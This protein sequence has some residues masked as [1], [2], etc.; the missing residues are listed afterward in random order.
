[1]LNTR[2]AFLY[3]VSIL[4]FNF[5]R[6]FFYRLFF[7]YEIEDSSIGFGTQIDCEQVFLKGS[8]IGGKNIVNCKS[9][10][11]LES[12]IGNANQFTGLKTIKLEN[13]SISNNNSFSGFIS[14][15]MSGELDNRSDIGNFNRFFLGAWSRELK[16]GTVQLQP[17]AKITSSHLFDL[18]CDIVI[19]RNSVIAGRESQFW[20]HGVGINKSINIGDL[21]YI[22]S[23]CRFAPGA[24]T[25]N[26]IIVGMGSVVTKHI[27]C[28]NAMIAGV[29][30]KIIKSNY[31][32]RSKDYLAT[33]EVEL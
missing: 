7:N 22:G 31:D 14:L 20:T 3:F 32:F 1:M 12:S 8:K 28:N 13:A 15:V 5:L 23:A 21:C 26:N 18:V 4:P 9:L 6:L 2:K 10:S 24:A 11:L 27:E 19:G 33:G 17:G 29:P 25:G 16:N 30:A